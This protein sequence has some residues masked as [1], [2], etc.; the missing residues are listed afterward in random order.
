V[1]TFASH[2]T[3]NAGVVT[4]FERQGTTWSLPGEVPDE[5]SQEHRVRVIAGSTSLAGATTALE[6]NS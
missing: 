1:K 3:G 6:L 4:L 5:W 2:P